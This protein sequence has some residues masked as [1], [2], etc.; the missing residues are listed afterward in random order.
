MLGLALV[1]LASSTGVAQAALPPIHHVYTIVLETENASTTSAPSSPA[2]YLSKTLRAQGVSL[3]NY[4]GIGHVSADNYIAMISGQ[5][6]NLDT[7]TDCMFYSSFP[8]DTIGAYDQVQGEGCVYPTGV[9]T[10]VSQLN[11]AGLA[12]RDYND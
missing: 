11:A 8:A 7:Q 4:Y 12:W 9:P 10:I 3:P 2:P 5:A 1:A 6:P